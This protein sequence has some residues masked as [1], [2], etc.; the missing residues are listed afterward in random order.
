MVLCIILWV[1]ICFEI[2]RPLHGGGSCYGG[3]SIGIRYC[4][5]N[6]ARGIWQKR[7][8]LDVTMLILELCI[9]LCINICIEIVK[10]LHC[11]CSCYGGGVIGIRYYI[12]NSARNIWYKRLGL[13]VT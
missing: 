10:P 13:D 1:Y 2:V 3:G 12:I 8:G 11:G 9:I 7:V 6:F 5:I 4:I